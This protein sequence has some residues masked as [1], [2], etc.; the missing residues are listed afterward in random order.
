MRSQVEQLARHPILAEL[1]IRRQSVL[2]LSNI[3]KNT[4]ALRIRLLGQKCQSS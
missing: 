4:S 3:W 2:L 1:A